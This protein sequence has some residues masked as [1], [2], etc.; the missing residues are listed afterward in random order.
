MSRV[1][2][3][4]MPSPALTMASELNS[5]AIPSAMTTTARTRPAGI[6]SLGFGSESMAQNWK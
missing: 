5:A 6:V 3:S 1:V 2:P 4:F